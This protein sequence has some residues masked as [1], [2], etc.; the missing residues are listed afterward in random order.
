MIF[1]TKGE[2]TQALRDYNYICDLISD[3]K[4]EYDKLHYLRYEK[5]GSP[6]DYE[7]VGYKNGETIRQIKLH[8]NVSQETITESREH[9]DK[10][11]QENLDRTAELAIKKANIESDLN[12]I[13]EPLRSILITR[14]IDGKRYRDVCKKYEKLY[15]DENGMHKYIKRGLSRYFEK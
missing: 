9:L 2:F 12:S 14:F 4:N 6:L 3:L 1:I 11:I 10:K 15:L 7:I 13:K 8:G 5:I